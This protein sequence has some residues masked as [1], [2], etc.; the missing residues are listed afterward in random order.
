MSLATDRKITFALST[1]LAVLL[2]VVAIAIVSTRRL[3][4]ATQWASNTA[5]VHGE[6]RAFDDMV[7]EARAD[8]RGY[9]LTGD[10]VYLR[11]YA[12]A[13]DS[14]RY[15]L[16]NLRGLTTSDSAQQRMVRD[17]ATLF[18]ARV[19]ALRRTA[20]LGVHT[21]RTAGAEA[22]ALTSGD[23]M[24]REMATVLAAL[25]RHE[26]TLQ[27]QQMA[28]ERWNA[29]AVWTVLLSLA[30]FAIVLVLLVRHSIVRDLLG[31]ARAEKALRASE[32][33]FAGILSIAAD[34]IVT[35]DE[36]QR[37][38][39]FNLG[40][41]SIF[42]YAAGEVIGQPLEVL[43][44]ERFAAGHRAHVREFAR[45]PRESERFGS[46]PEVIGR[47][48]SGEEFTAEAS[49]SKLA[50]AEGTLFTIVLRD[51]TERKRRDRLE[52]ALATVGAQIALASEYDDRLAVVAQ[53]PVPVVGS[54]CLLDV[55]EEDGDH[56]SVLRRVPSTHPDPALD[57]ALREFGDP[58]GARPRSPRVLDV[59][60]TGQPAC[61][62][63]AQQQLQGRGAD[64]ELRGLAAIMD[65]DSIL[66]VPVVR[67]DAILGT[68][69]IGSA[70]GTSFGAT[71]LEAARVMAER[72][73]MA[74][75][76]G[77]L[78][79][80]ARRAT[81][82]RDQVLGMVSHDLRNPLSAIAMCARTL[83]STPATDD[84]ERRHQCQTILDASGLMQR[85]LQDLLDV[86]AL[87]AGHLSMDMDEQAIAPLL[88]AT[89][90]MFA[91]RAA[92]QSLGFVVECA[93]GLP[94]VQGD[95][96]RLVQVLANLVSNA[97]KFTP[98][99]GTIA[100]R[101]AA[102]ADEVV[103]TVSDTGPGIPAADL[104]HLFERFWHRQHTNGKRGYGLGLAIAHG[105]VAA[106]GG[107]IRVESA[108]GQ[109]STFS[110]A[111]PAVRA[112]LPVAAPA[113]V[114]GVPGIAGVPGLPVA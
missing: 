109:G 16:D 76:N 101:A 50:T 65:S 44:P 15:S 56:G 36:E 2:L 94:Y 34:G 1:S 41:E 14:A 85:L 20:A 68:M 102:E 110:V 79:R 28:A 73:G 19:G 47:R 63:N 83:L 86:A 3:M 37:I 35:I 5:L 39:H 4:R 57:E 80:K 112:A 48:R 40:A 25:D 88:E 64:G 26:R 60:Q 52:H 77:R 105:I 33:R 8:V 84:A 66:V 12:V 91:T 7:D 70:P 17:L 9:L 43:L 42:G 103:L 95:G 98:D 100:V 27:G 22:R 38:V 69:T 23:L 72:G 45:A 75:D 114:P 51:V 29:D 107:R 21:D 111:L 97:L 13:I 74:I 18:D 81:L 30:L 61:I 6:L 99:G 67:G 31:R 89:R 11:E 96:G 71:D 108:P 54:W 53:L 55:V 92:A 10:S 93:P 78:L 62:P 104:P 58:A 24:T 90:E 59:L 49:M 46:R 82:A 32:A 87:E 113:R 106:H